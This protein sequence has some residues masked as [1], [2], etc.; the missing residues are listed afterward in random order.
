MLPRSAY[1]RFR[2]ALTALF[3]MEAEMT[4]RRNE[5]DAARRRIPILRAC[6][7]RLTP[8]RGLEPR[9]REMVLAATLAIDINNSKAFARAFRDIADQA[10]IPEPR[11]GVSPHQRLLNYLGLKATASSMSRACRQIEA[12]VKAGWSKKE[13]E[14]RIMAGPSKIA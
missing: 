13:I 2:G 1:R 4:S 3:S 8:R 7:R 11:A 5:I 14:R 10:G 6:V 9:R 12:C